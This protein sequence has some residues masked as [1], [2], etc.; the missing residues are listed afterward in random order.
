M[1]VTD[2]SWGFNG[3]FLFASTHDGKVTS[4]HF[5]PGVLGQPISEFE[6]RE[7]TMINDLKLE[8]EKFN[9]V[10]DEFERINNKSKEIIE[11]ASKFK[12]Q[13]KE[14]IAQNREIKLK[15]EAKGNLLTTCELKFKDINVPKSV[16]KSFT[17]L[18]VISFSFNKPF[19]SK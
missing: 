2:L 19:D 3:N 11:S 18:G 6:K 13:N 12:T 9:E 7:I 4:F 15:L 17:N 16:K 14:I 8:K 10:K 1:G 5:K